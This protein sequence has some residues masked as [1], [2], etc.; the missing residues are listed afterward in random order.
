MRTRGPSAHQI[1]PSPSQTLTGVQLKDWP[2]GTMAAATIIKM[3][4]RMLLRLGRGPSL[5]DS[6]DRLHEWVLRQRRELHYSFENRY[7]AARS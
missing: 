2:A 7:Q 6:Q 5:D 1:G 4:I 3:L